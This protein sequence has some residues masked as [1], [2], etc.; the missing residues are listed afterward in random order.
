MKIQAPEPRSRQSEPEGLE[1]LEQLC[2]HK[3]PG[4]S[5]PTGPRSAPQQLHVSTQQPPLFKERCY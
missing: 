3:H 4:R 1:G 2:F 5:C